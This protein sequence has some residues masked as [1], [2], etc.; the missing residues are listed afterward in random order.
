VLGGVLLLSMIDRG[1]NLMRVEVFLQQVVQGL[2]ILFAMFIDAQRVRF[3]APVSD[4]QPDEED[5][6]PAAPATGG[7]DGRP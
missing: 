3:Q 7:G 5:L 4:D 6:A 1:L 2:I